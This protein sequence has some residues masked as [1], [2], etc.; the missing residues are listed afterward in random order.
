MFN[1]PFPTKIET[2]KV[3]IHDEAKDK[4]VLIIA[5]VCPSA[6]ALAELKEG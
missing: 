4:Y 1:L 5:L 2:I 6:I 3:E